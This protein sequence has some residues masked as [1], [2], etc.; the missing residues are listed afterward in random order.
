MTRYTLNNRGRA[1]FIYGP[2]S[3]FVILAATTNILDLIVTW[4]FG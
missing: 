2:T 1:I 4:I 3:V